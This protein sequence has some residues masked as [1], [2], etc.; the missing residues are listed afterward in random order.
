MTRHSY[1]WIFFL[2]GF[3]YFIFVDETDFHN[4]TGYNMFSK[5]DDFIWR[6][7]LGYYGIKSSH[8]GI[9]FISL[10]DMD[11]AGKFFVEKKKLW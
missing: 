10:V 6:E 7:C 9:A 4:K 8:S 5:N 11:F 1:K 2:F 3:P